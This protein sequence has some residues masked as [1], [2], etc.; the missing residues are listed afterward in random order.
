[1]SES[2]NAEAFCNF[3]RQAQT[4]KLF[5]N[6]EAEASGKPFGRCHRFRRPLHRTRAIPDIC[7]FG[8]QN[9]SHDGIVRRSGRQTHSRPWLWLR[10]ALDCQVKYFLFLLV[11]FL[12]I[13]YSSLM[14]CTFVVGID[15]D[16][17]AL[18]MAAANIC[19]FGMEESIDL[20]RGNVANLS[21]KTFDTVVTNPPFG[22]RCKGADMV[23][24]KAA[25]GHCTTAV[26]SLHKTSTRQVFLR[27]FSWISI[28]LVEAYREKGG[29]LGRQN[30][31][32]C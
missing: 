17:G 21:L 7:P 32:C 1:M 20:I 10:N 4:L 30:G 5:S 8:S 12:L 16:K 19:D 27:I 18:E 14:G 11:S 24:L 3:A 2:S 31:S 28:D 15:I 13:L 25:I 23:F 26:Y 22:T 29:R 6:H 9:D